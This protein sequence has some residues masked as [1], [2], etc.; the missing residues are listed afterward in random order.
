VMIDHVNLYE[1]V[2]S[3]YCNLI[4]WKTGSKITPSSVHHLP[5]HLILFAIP[6]NLIPDIL[7]T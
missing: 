4:A 5:L 3:G 2:G 7:C 1:I 6:C